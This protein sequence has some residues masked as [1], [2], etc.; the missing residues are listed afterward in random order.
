MYI[1]LLTRI[2]NQDLPFDE[3]VEK[4]ALKS[5]VD[6][7]AL[8]RFTLKKHGPNCF[9][10]AKIAILILNQKIRPFTIK[11]NKLLQKKT[12]SKKEKDKFRNEVKHLQVELKKYILLLSKILGVEDGININNG[13]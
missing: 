1:E 13:L 6:L 5:I 11:W 2:T 8:T 10:F 9:E 12:I 7:F 4:T 3:S